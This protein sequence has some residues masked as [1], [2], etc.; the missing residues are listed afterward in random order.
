MGL[1]KLHNVFLCF[2]SPLQLGKYSKVEFNSDGESWVMKLIWTTGHLRI[3]KLYLL[4]VGDIVHFI[5]LFS[6][7]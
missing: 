1:K 5:Y 4:S 7:L 6:D 3:A 2:F